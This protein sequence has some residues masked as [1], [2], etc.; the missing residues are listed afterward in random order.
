MRWLRIHGALVTPP[1]TPP[2]RHV[3]AFYK[4]RGYNYSDNS[5]QT[6]T[7]SITWNCL[8]TSKFYCRL[9]RTFFFSNKKIAKESCSRDIVWPQMKVEHGTIAW[10]FLRNC[11]KER[12]QSNPA[13]MM[14]WSI[15]NMKIIGY[16]QTYIVLQISFN[17]LICGIHPSDRRWIKKMWSDWIAW[18]TTGSNCVL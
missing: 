14:A 12:K 2:L 3:I 5:K 15:N 10:L 7:P 6:D 16:Q 8:W 13:W 9:G 11:R 18:P 17:S 4:R 1:P